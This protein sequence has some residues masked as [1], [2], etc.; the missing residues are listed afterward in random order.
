MATEPIQATK[1]GAGN[2]SPPPPMQRWGGVGAVLGGAL[3]GAWGYLHGNIALPYSDAVVAR[4]MSLFLHALFLAGL[5]GLY[6]CWRRTGGWLGAAGFGVGFFGVLLEMSQG[7]HGVLFES[8]VVDVDSW[9]AYVRAVTGL[10]AKLLTWPP[11]TPVGL[12]AIGMN[13][14]GARRALRVLGYLL[15]A[16]GFCGCAYAFTEPGGVVEEMGFAHVLFG[17]LYSL[18]WMVLGCL[19]LRPNSLEPRRFS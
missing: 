14:V 9:H 19:L 10:P 12:A 7:I 17:A 6:A 1:R 8:G 2:A 16:T 4:A 5:A 13:F 15:L 18:S 11:W 3:L